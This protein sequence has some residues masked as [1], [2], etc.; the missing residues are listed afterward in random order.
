MVVSTLGAGHRAL[1]FLQWLLQRSAEETILAVQ[2]VG[3]FERVGRFAFVRSAEV[4]HVGNE[5]LKI[6]K[7]VMLLLS[8]LSRN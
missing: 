6:L 2:T 3:C 4:H 7:R 1:F 8:P 5:R